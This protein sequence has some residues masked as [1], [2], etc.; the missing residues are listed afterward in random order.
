MP[1]AGIDVP[2][3]I[4]VFN[5][6]EPTARVFARIRDA[7]PGQLFV[8]ADGPRPDHPADAAAC[9]GVRELIEQGV[10]W[11]CEVVRIYADTNLG[12]AAR[13][14]SGITAVFGQVEQAIILE[15][16]CLPDPSFFPYCKELLQR[17]GDDER[18]AQIAGCSFRRSPPAGGES[19]YFSRYPHCWGWATWRRAW[20]EYDHDMAWTD[21]SRRSAVMR[22]IESSEERAYWEH[23]FSGTH[24][25]LHDSWA[26][27]WTLACW[28]RNRLSI[29]A[30]KNLVSNIG[31]G[32]QATHTRNDSAIADLPVHAMELPLVHPVKVVRDIDAD[33]ATSELCFR[34]FGFW[35][36]SWLK[37]RHRTAPG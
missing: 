36:R 37:F 7:R 8:V 30:A 16:D 24:R 14:S 12:C 1:P 28:D 11:P 25:D 33:L 35:K 13:V 29:V 21:T 32:P 2:V 17:F 4:L 6:P 31:Y 27:R 19:Y 22:N 15:D 34:R 26:Y 3:V 23:A 9:R 18:V 5:R 10:D 20:R